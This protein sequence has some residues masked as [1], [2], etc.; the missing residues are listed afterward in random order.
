MFFLLSGEGSTDVGLGDHAGVC[1]GADF[2]YGPMTAIVDR[3]VD[4]AHQ[5]SILAFE[6]CGFVSESDLAGRASELKTAKKSVRLP[7]IKTP[8]ETRYFFNTAR[9]LARIALE[10]EAEQDEEIIAVLFRDSDGTASAN[11]GLWSDKRQSMVHGFEEENCGRGVPMIPK[12][13]SEAWLL[14]ATKANPY[15]DCDTLE[16][17]SG[18]DKS[19]NSLKNQL[20]ACFAVPPN[21]ENLAEMVMDGTIDIDRIQMPSFK[22]FRDRLVAVLV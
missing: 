19:P 7:G 21:R 16:D 5:Y 22:A 17:S 18:N 2:K 3:I 11:R 1:R 10:R 6:A 20:V 15:I 13:K 4:K 14:C 8:K 12:P 9:V